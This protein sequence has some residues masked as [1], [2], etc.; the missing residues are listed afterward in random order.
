MPWQDFF[1]RR[2]TDAVRERETSILF[3]HVDSTSEDPGRYL[4]NHFH[5]DAAFRP[6]KK[7]VDFLRE[8]RVLANRVVCVTVEADYAQNWI[9]FIKAYRSSS[10]QDGLF[11]LITQAAPPAGTV[12]NVRFWEYDSFVS[13]YDALVFAGLLTDN[14]LSVEQKRYVSTMAVSLLGADA[15]GIANF[16]GDYRFDIDDPERFFT[17]LD[18]G[19]SRRVWTAQVQTL[20]PLIMR[21][22]R[23]FIDIWRARVED[24]LAY[25]S[26]AFSEGLLDSNHEPVESPDELELAALLF[27][28]KN[29]RRDMDGNETEDYI[30]YVPDEDARIR[31]RLL[32]NMR[33]QIAHGKV[34]P[35]EDVVRLL[36]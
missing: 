15:R 20:F 29:R 28:M 35:V 24:A 21:E 3:E 25:A 6:T 10:P 1:F 27:L 36:Q 17:Y 18:T 16:L 7:T 23:A 2:V 26:Q 19:L 8:R 5:L 13:D 30:L 14:A 32:Y 34:C 12:K 9:T 22:C 31:L 33:N 4:V 11:L